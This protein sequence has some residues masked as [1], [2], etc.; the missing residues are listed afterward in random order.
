MSR[1]QRALPR[2]TA[3][4]L[5]PPVIPPAA[6]QGPRLS[7]MIPT[8]NCAEYLRVA[9]SSVLAQDPGPD[10]ME[11]EV[12]DDCSTADDPQR[13]VDEL[14]RGR[15][16]FFRQPSNV[17][18]IENFNTCIRR[19]SGNLVH[20]LHGDDYVLPGF[21]AEILRI[22]DVHASA[23]L[24]ATRVQFVDADGAHQQDS[25]AV[26]AAEAGPIRDAALFE[27]GTPLQF[28]GVVVR[29]SAYEAAGG[30]LPVLVHVADMEMWRRLTAQ[31]GLVMSP[32]VLAAYRIFGEQ[33]SSRV[34]R[35]AENLLDLDRF[36]VIMASNQPVS[37]PTELMALARR[38]GYRQWRKALHRGDKEAAAN[39][40]AYVRGRAEPSEWARWVAGSALRR[41]R[42]KR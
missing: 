29:R 11:I 15:V 41:L 34:R 24:Y 21:Y 9:L 35:S 33:H 30:F 39:A 20:I 31:S 16:R 18:A 17:G 10:V 3:E 12:V 32:E 28:A 5:T 6:T 14:G 38:A 1:H 37:D 36:A 13:V 2:L 40:L 26:P 22:A 23:G 4:Q 25:M 42:P 27:R 8:F 7:V 19:S